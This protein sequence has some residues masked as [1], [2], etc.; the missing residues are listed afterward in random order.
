ML[1]FFR[2]FAGS[3]ASRPAPYQEDVLSE[4]SRFGT[5]KI[6]PSIEIPEAEDIFRITGS[7]IY[8]ST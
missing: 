2:F 1:I 4:L 6:A 8:S 7:L 5:T 3:S